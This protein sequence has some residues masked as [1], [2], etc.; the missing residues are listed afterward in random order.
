MAVAPLRQT[1]PSA[2]PLLTEEPTVSPGGT[3]VM[4]VKQAPRMSLCAGMNDR[5]P[6]TLRVSAAGWCGL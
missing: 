2:S 4:W 6:Y 1:A 3:P 5:A